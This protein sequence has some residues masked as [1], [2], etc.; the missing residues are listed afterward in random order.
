MN[1][2]QYMPFESISPNIITW[3]EARE[4]PGLYGTGFFAIFSPYEYIFYVTARHCIQKIMEEENNCCLQIPIQLGSKKNIPFSFCLECNTENS[5]DSEREDIAVLVVDKDKLNST[6]Y[7]CLKKRALKL[8]H[9]DDIDFLLRFGVQN[10]IKLR[11][12]GFPLHNAPDGKNY[13][14]YEEPIINLQ[15]RGFNGILDKDDC[16]PNQYIIKDTNWQGDSYSGF[17]GSPVIYLQ[18]EPDGK[19]RCFPIGVIVRAGGKIARFV[20]I[21]MVTNTIAAFICNELNLTE[22]RIK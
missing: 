18:P 5:L 13:V 4:F 9:Q 3:R 7:V 8:I 20:N 10:K 11:T 15:P 14:D 19:V 21:N 17:S 12:I 16:W 2:K 22:R 6:E 1:T